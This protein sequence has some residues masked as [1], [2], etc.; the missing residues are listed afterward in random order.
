MM[1]SLIGRLF[2]FRAKFKSEIKRKKGS[3]KLSK[4]EK[5]TLIEETDYISKLK[6]TFACDHQSHTHPK[7]KRK[8]NHGHSYSLYSPDKPLE[9]DFKRDSEPDENVVREDPITIKE[10]RAL[11]AVIK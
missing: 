8:L 5:D 4:R 7:E 3:K 6:K 10:K 11:R 1:S 9:T 2:H